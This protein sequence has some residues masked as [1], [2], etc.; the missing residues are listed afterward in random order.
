MRI[1]IEFYRTRDADGA[2]EVL[3]AMHLEDLLTEMGHQVIGSCGRLNEA[4]ELARRQGVDR[5]DDGV[6][7]REGSAPSIA[8]EAATRPAPT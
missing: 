3:V 2:H 6:S 7:D 4:M 8:E 1:V 5:Q